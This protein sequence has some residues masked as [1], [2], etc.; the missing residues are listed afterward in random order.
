M[1]NKQ[2]K[3][4]K[5][6]IVKLSCIFLERND[7]CLDSLDKLRSTK[8]SV[9]KIRLEELMKSRTRLSPIVIKKENEPTRPY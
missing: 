5:W 8:M 3:L 6:I 1:E 7:V 9:L 4:S 2:G